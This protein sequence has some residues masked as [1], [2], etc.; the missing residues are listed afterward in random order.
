MQKKPCNMERDEWAAALSKR[1]IDRMGKDVF[2]E[3]E[4]TKDFWTDF[5]IACHEFFEDEEGCINH[6]EMLGS[7]T[8]Q[9]LLCVNKS[10]FIYDP[11]KE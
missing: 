4:L 11:N 9:W 3:A 7:C 10:E 8:K 1:L 5:T 6:Y 2:T